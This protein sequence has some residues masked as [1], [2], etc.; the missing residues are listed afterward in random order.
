MAI[1]AQAAQQAHSI[2]TQGSRQTLNTPAQQRTAAPSAPIRA[3]EQIQRRLPAQQSSVA[4]P[5]QTRQQMPSGSALAQ[6]VQSAQLEKLSKLRKDYIATGTVVESLKWRL[7]HDARNLSVEDSKGIVRLVNS[8]DHEI[9]SMYSN[10][11]DS[12]EQVIFVYEDVLNN[13]RTNVI[14]TLTKQIQDLIRSKTAPR[15]ESQSMEFDLS[16]ST[17][18]GIQ[19]DDNKAENANLPAFRRSTIPFAPASETAS[20]FNFRKPLFSVDPNVN[21]AALNNQ[22]LKSKL[23]D[24]QKEISSLFDEILSQHPNNTQLRQNKASLISTLEAS[25]RLIN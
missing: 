18:R 24:L 12:L 10:G 4:I 16:A 19:I 23:N 25:Q 13:W 7:A 3:S 9:Y 11:Q 14:P 15:A 22:A 1:S 21:V 6:N 5:T 2:L 17:S 8:K 20:S